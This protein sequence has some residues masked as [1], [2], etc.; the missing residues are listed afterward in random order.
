MHVVH[1]VNTHFANIAII[2]DTRFRYTCQ[3]GPVR[4]QVAPR[5]V[6]PGKET[7]DTKLLRMQASEWIHILPRA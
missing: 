1:C 6:N 4:I 2:H 3:D 7:D 5:G